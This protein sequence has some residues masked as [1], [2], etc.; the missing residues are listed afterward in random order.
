M[1][2]VFPAGLLIFSARKP[3]Q[4]SITLKIVGTKFFLAP[5]QNYV[6]CNL[7]EMK[8]VCFIEL[9]WNGDI[10]A[11]LAAFALIVGPL[12]QCGFWTDA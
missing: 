7:R 8:S 2:S 5:L 4:S 9:R 11:I 12:S 10:K 1:D 3:P 6:C